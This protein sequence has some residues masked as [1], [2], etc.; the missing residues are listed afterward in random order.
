MTLG[1]EGEWPGEGELLAHLEWIRALKSFSKHDGGLRSWPPS[2][3][4][5]KELTIDLN[6]PVSEKTVHIS[7]QPAASCTQTSSCFFFFFKTARGERELIISSLHFCWQL[8]KK[9]W[10]DL[11]VYRAFRIGSYE[12]RFF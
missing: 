11:R 8:L 2:G 3:G 4:L 5:L 10:A 1:E 7:C 6:K 9:I 12:R